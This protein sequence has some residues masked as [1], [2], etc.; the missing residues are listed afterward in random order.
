MAPCSP[1]RPAGIPGGV[2]ELIL[3]RLV[4]EGAAVYERPL[5][6][7]IKSLMKNF[8]GEGIRSY[9]RMIIWSYD[10][11][12]IGSEIIRAIEAQETFT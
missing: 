4:P 3:G 9:D 10:H 2:P 11:T 8:I 5:P 7:T 12:T 6:G 1:E